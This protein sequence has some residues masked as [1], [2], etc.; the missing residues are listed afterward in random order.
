MIL[1]KRIILSDR[2]KVRIILE[3]DEEICSIDPEFKKG[4]IRKYVHQFK[5]ELNWIIYNEECNCDNKAKGT[6]NM[7]GTPRKHKKYVK[8]WV[9]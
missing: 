2:Q 6:L 5:N 9:I 7:D 8:D 3:M 4:I 1:S